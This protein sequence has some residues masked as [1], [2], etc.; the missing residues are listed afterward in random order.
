MGGN[1]AA[2]NAIRARDAGQF[3]VSYQ[4]LFYPVTDVTLSFQSWKLFAQVP[5]LTR[6]IDS[7]ALAL[8]TVF[9]TTSVSV[10]SN[11]ETQILHLSW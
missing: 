1:L 3:K 7:A 8:R 4:V 5:W 2:V 11:P 10:C 6:V 9:N